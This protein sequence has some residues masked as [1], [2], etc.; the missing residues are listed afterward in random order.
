M[1]S[2]LITSVILLPLVTM[3]FQ[4]EIDSDAKN[5][6]EKGLDWLGRNQNR[7]GSY[8]SGN[9][10]VATT[11]LAGVALLAGGNTPT[12]GM[13]SENVRRA[14]D[15]ILKMVSKDGYINEG[16]SMGGRGSGMHGHGFAI[17]FLASAYGMTGPE[18]DNAELK[19][20]LMK[21][22]KLTEKCQSSNGGWTYHPKSQGEEG[23]VTIT[24]VA[25][26][27]AARNA[28]LTVNLETINKA[29]KYI[30]GTTNDNGW[31]QYNWGS[32]GGGMQSITL[33]AKG[34]SV[35]TYLGEYKNKKLDKML[36]NI[37]KNLSGGG[38]RGYYGLTKLYMGIATH[39]AGGEYWRKFWDHSKKDLVKKQSSDGGWK[40][41][42]ESQQYGGAFGTA[43]ALIV[44]QIPY[45]Y[46][47]ILQ[48]ASE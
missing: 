47:P 21:A 20:K 34:A 29:I 28:G 1:K 16:T 2:F 43:C 48:S 3:S 14:L 22:I 40:S 8:G 38:R 19:Q 23:S 6:I 32:K 31:V 26:L 39:Q 17:L 13:Y 42:Q 44:L 18:Y 27:R 37:M 33:T 35:L 25:G 4:D 12:R 46:L 9:A 7:D 15:Y 36:D 10:N 41:E 30:I 24:Q 11:S 45:R 5:A